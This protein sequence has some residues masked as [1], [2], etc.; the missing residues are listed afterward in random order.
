MV[1]EQQTNSKYSTGSFMFD[2]K[3]DEH[4]L[5]YRFKNFWS[6]PCLCSIFLMLISQLQVV[7]DVGF[8]YYTLHTPEFV[9]PKYH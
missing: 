1:Q 5:I 6:S 8:V 3:L 7:C 4:Y 2:I 9:N